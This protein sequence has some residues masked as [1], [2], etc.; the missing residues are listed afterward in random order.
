MDLFS[1]H[2][3]LRVVLLIALAG[4]STR[5]VGELYYEGALYSTQ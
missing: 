1:K 4:Y 5:V 3:W 2:D